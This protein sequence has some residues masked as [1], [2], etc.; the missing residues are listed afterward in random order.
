MPFRRPDHKIYL[1][2]LLK[3]LRGVELNVDYLF[4]GI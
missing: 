4:L 2:T 1:M 3:K